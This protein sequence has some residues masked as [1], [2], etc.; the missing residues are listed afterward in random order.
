M[1][2][3]NSLVGCAGLILTALLLVVVG[4]NQSS[5]ESAPATSVSPNPALQSTRTSEQSG[6]LAEIDSEHGHQT[7]GHGG[8]IVSLGRDSYH[9]E[10]IVTEQGELQL[11]TLGNDE[12]RVLDIEEQE[13][14]AYV[15]SSGGTDSI[16]LQLQSKAQS[17]GQDG[18]SV[19]IVDPEPTPLMA[20]EKSL[21][22]LNIQTADGDIVRDF[23]VLHEQLVHL[24]VVRDGLDE[25]AHLHP[26]VDDRG[27]LRTTYTFSKAGNYRLFADYQAKG[28]HASVAKALLHVS[29]PELEPE[30]LLVNAPGNV[31]ADGLQVKIAI[32]SSSVGAATQL[33]FE[34][35][36]EAGRAIK[37]LS[38]YLGARG[39]LVVLNAA[40]DVYVHAHPLFAM[41]RCGWSSSCFF[42]C[43][44]SESALV[45]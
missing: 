4:C 19:L 34:L 23:D 20:G 42:L 11:Y 26:T 41:P 29:G 2:R 1:L 9:V 31:S 36:D 25:F 5:P 22:K 28:K 12:T 3:F 15:K 39:H 37:D 40:G 18:N 10:A 13:L 30:P 24:I 16:S 27:N 14:V 6:A 8:I 35:A 21:L 32:P 45:P 44:T 33:R 43:G 38:P 17:T 7:G